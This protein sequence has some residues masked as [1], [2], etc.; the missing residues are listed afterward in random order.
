MKRKAARLVVALCVLVA[1]LV[2]AFCLQ[3]CHPCIYIPHGPGVAD[4]TLLEQGTVP[5]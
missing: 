3:T 4:S 2:T 5:Q 1:L